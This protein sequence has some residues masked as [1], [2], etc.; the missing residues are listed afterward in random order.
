MVYFDYIKNSRFVVLIKDIVDQIF[1]Y[2]LENLLGLSI[3]NDLVLVFLAVS[4]LTSLLLLFFVP[5]PLVTIST[6]LFV[7]HDISVPSLLLGIGISSYFG[8]FLGDRGAFDL[9]SKTITILREK[10]LSFSEERKLWVEF[11][12]IASVAFL[13][14]VPV[15]PYTIVNIALG[16]IGIRPLMVTFGSVIGLFPNIL[17][18]AMG[19]NLLI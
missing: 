10:M 11:R 4:L 3:E 15:A 1:P 9:K 6:I 2:F 8:A 12:S 5:V 7:N 17:L 14:H 16:Q 13:R 18:L 19:K